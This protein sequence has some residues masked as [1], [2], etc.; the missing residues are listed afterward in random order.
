MRG[1]LTPG[2][3]GIVPGSYLSSPSTAPPHAVCNAFFGFG[4]HRLSGCRAQPSASA[5]TVAA[6]DA[7]RAGWA[8]RWGR[9]A[10][11]GAAAVASFLA[12]R[13]D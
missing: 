2:E 6:V 9:R 4:M 13:V 3:G 8:A 10:L 1:A 7:L 11:R 5:Q 12:G